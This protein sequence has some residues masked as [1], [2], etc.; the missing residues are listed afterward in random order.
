MLGNQCPH[1]GLHTGPWAQKAHFFPDT[2]LPG[3]GPLRA[4][5]GPRLALHRH[6]EGTQQV[7]D[8]HRPW[9]WTCHGGLGHWGQG[10][11]AGGH[12]T[13]VHLGLAE[14]QF[15]LHRITRHGALGQTDKHIQTVD[16]DV[17]DSSHRREALF[18]LLTCQ[19]CQKPGGTR[20]GEIPPR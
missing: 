8:E 7:G 15:S 14:S 12:G 11:R 5:P 3:L 2:F 9:I 17:K 10:A 13:R 1:A 18:L 6:G 4:M 16:R 20:W 19:S